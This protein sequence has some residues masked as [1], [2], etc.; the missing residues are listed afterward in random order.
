M[1]VLVDHKDLHSSYIQLCQQLNL[2]QSGCEKAWSLYTEVQKRERLPPMAEP[3]HW[4]VC[5]LYLVCSQA[6][7]ESVSGEELQGSGV[8]L[9]EVRNKPLV[10]LHSC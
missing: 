5:A 8:S 1:S 10:T 2:D 3:L 4:L 9:V 7:V 6:R